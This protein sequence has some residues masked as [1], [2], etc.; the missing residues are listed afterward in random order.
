M[1]QRHIFTKVIICSVQRHRLTKQKRLFIKKPPTGGFEIKKN[2]M[3]PRKHLQQM[4][5][6]N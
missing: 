4:R 2:Q 6:G 3:V 1:Q 5:R